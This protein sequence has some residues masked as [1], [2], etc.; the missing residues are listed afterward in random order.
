VYELKKLPRR[1][2]EPTGRLRRPERLSRHQLP[3][4]S[5]PVE[6]LELVLN[7]GEHG[8]MAGPDQD[9]PCILEG[10]EKI[11]GLLQVVDDVARRLRI[12]RCVHADVTLLTVV[13]SEKFRIEL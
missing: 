1:Y 10:C 12:L 6:H 11:Q 2:I 7:L 9:V 4:W 13:G 8:E 5:K 3:P